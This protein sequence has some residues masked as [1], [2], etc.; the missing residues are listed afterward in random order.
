MASSTRALE[1]LTG[2][3]DATV[4]QELKKLTGL[5]AVDARRDGIHMYYRQ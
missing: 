3:S 5:S 1:W 4:M 2:L